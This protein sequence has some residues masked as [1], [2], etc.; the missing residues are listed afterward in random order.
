[1]VIEENNNT[2]IEI[3]IIIIGVI[4]LHVV[5]INGFTLITNTIT[6]AKMPIMRRA[7]P[8]TCHI[9]KGASKAKI[10]TIPVISSEIDEVRGC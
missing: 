9:I 7:I 3:G 1:M 2:I 5:K 10:P 4:S 6:M 8:E